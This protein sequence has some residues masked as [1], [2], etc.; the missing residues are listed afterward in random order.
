MIRLYILI[1]IIL[2]SIIVGCKK[3]DS[4]IQTGNTS[5]NYPSFTG[6]TSTDNSG[7]PTG[8]NDPTDWTNDTNWVYSEENLFPQLQFLTSDFEAYSNIEVHP[9][10]PNPASSNPSVQITKAS[11]VL[12]SFKVVN[13]TF[14]VIASMDSIYSNAFTINTETIISPADTMIRIYYLLERNDSCLYKGHGDIKIN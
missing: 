11:D 4:N 3:D 14:N 9:A 12:L 5:N 1:I 13:S 6:Y 2:T 10:Y 7:V 8:L